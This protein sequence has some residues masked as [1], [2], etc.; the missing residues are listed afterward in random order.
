MGQRMCDW[1][2]ERHGATV[3]DHH[4]TVMDGDSSYL[5]TTVNS[6]FTTAEKNRP[7]SETD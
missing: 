4:Q 1:I 5:D 7:L 3:E 2:P 6:L